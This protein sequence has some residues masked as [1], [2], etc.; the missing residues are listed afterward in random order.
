MAKQLIV[1]DIDGVLSDDS[2]RHHLLS[3]DENHGSKK[4]QMYY[5]E[6][7]NDAPLTLGRR[8]HFAWETEPSVEIYYATGRP[9]R[10]REA[11][12]DWFVKN[13]ITRDKPNAY[14]LF[15][16]PDDCYLSNAGLK[17]S[18]VDRLGVENIGAWY[19]DHPGVIQML[20]DWGVPA[21]WIPA[22]GWTNHPEPSFRMTTGTYERFIA[23]SATYPGHDDPDSIMALIYCLLGLGEAGELQ[24]KGKKI[25][26]D[27]GGR[28]THER[29]E[30]M[31]DELGD[32]LWYVVRT[33]HHLGYSLHEL[34]AR[35][36]DKLSG[37][38]ERGTIK[39]DGDVR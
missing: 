20:R 2:H 6:A 31:M 16:R 4:W 28:L 11:T 14:H 27:D 8:L 10:Y 25:L 37:R 5:D 23:T 30:A 9:E 24:G 19:D 21:T 13:D 33:A 7:V 15:M 34:M 1:F 17:R 29:R 18:V 32:V 22:K 35:N 39:G 3:D 26:R 38:M 36:A 12:V